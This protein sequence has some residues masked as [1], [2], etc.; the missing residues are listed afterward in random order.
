M[1]STILEGDPVLLREGLLPLYIVGASET[2]NIEQYCQHMKSTIL[3][4]DPVLLREGLLPLYIVGAS[5]TRNI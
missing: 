4:G 3:E 2:I 5:E 1:K